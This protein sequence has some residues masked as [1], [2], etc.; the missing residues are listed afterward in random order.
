MGVFFDEFVDELLLEV[1]FV[2]PELAGIVHQ[3][4][5]QVGAVDI[6]LAVSIELDE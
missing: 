3:E 1:V 5:L 4:D 6:A 2:V